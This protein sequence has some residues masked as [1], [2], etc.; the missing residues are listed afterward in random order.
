MARPL[1]PTCHKGPFRR[2]AADLLDAECITSAA[3][4]TMQFSR[5][6]MLDTP[7]ECPQAHGNAEPCLI[8][9]PIP[10][11]PPHSRPKI[12]PNPAVPDDLNYC[13]PVNPKCRSTT[14]FEM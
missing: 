10:N 7:Q 13:G 6:P 14:Q 2:R 1:R 8:V 11:L 4:S 5:N 12:I 3:N 9:A